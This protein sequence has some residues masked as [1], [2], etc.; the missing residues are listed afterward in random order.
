MEKVDIRRRRLRSLGKGNTKSIGIFEKIGMK[1]AGWVDGRKGLLRCGANGVWQ[2]S[3]LKQEVDAYEEFC[4]EQF[5]LLKV[6]EEDNFKEINI[7]FDKIVPLRKKLS[8]ARN[9]LC[10]ASNNPKGLSLRKAGEENLTDVQVIARRTREKE[11]H[12]RP[13]QE[14]A[15]RCE[16]QLSDVVDEIF[17]ILSQVQESFD[18]ANRINHRLLQHVQRRIDVYWRSAARHMPD[19]PALPNVTFT[20]IAERGYEEH[21]KAVVEKAEKLREELAL[22]FKKEEA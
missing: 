1:Y 20:N 22:E 7:L 9:A 10:K 8:D 12:L 3:I 17:S 15:D 13:L 18:S 2:S 16:K 21:Y 6:E 11:E 19:L 4:A 5:G 14:E